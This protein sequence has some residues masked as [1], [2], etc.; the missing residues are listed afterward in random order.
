MIRLI[1]RSSPLLLLQDFEFL[2]A[3]SKPSMVSVIAKVAASRRL[4]VSH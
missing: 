3:S 1:V 4:H 2:L